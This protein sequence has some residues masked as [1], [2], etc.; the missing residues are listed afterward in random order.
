MAVVQNAISND[1]LTAAYAADAD[2]FQKMSA[3]ARE[4]SDRYWEALEKLTMR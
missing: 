1:R 3:A 2:R 4:K